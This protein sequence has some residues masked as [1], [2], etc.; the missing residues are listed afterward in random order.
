MNDVTTDP[1]NHE[2]SRSDTALRKGEPATLRCL[3][4]GALRCR[5][6]QPVAEPHERHV[7]AQAPLMR[8]PTHPRERDSMMPRRC[9]TRGGVRVSN[10]AKQLA[11]QHCRTS[12]DTALHRVLCTGGYG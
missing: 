2:L 1:E 5:R 11:G 12:P 7:E 10:W 9:V 3:L 4:L 8:S 6:R